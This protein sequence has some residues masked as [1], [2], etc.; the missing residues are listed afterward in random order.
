[1][2][3]PLSAAPTIQSCIV[4]ASRWTHHRPLAG[5]HAR[6]RA[7]PPRPR[8]AGHF[9]QPPRL[10]WDDYI[11]TGEA[12]DSVKVVT[13]ISRFEMCLKENA[14]VWGKT[15]MKEGKRSKAT[16][17]NFDIG[18]SFVQKMKKSNSKKKLA[19]K[20]VKA[21]MLSSANKRSDIVKG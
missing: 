16:K 19:L 11:S 9:R 21:K 13:D 20:A 17:K 6:Y 18:R 10:K 1:M 15:P 7:R 4:D 2:G 5:Q 8:S 14:A 3:R 12:H